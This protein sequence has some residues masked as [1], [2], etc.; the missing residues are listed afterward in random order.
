MVIWMWLAADGKSNT[1]LQSSLPHLTPGAS[2]VL[3][4]PLQQEVL[5][6]LWSVRQK[7]DAILQDLGKVFA[8]WFKN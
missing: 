7:Q 5:T 3:A 6:Q 4:Q 2:Y 1:H 8:S